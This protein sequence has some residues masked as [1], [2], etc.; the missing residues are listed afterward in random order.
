MHGWLFSV[1]WGVCGDLTAIL[2]WFTL[3]KQDFSPSIQCTSNPYLHGCLHMARFAL[4][5]VVPPAAMPHVAPRPIVVLTYSD[6][7]TSPAI[8]PRRLNMDFQITKILTAPVTGVLGELRSVL[9][10]LGCS[11]HAE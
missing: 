7:I 3:S 4:H 6:P 10:T 1:C 9:W 5:N 2:F 8:A 11:P